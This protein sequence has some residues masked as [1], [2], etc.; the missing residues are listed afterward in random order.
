MSCYHGLNIATGKGILIQYNKGA[1]VDA[2]FL[3]YNDAYLTRD[4]FFFFLINAKNIS[5]VKSVS[6]Y[7]TM[8]FVAYCVSAIFSLKAN[9]TGYL[10]FS[11]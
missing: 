11:Q 6:S 9:T 8:R 5:L 7:H 10:R 3:L 2:L 1:S 4:L